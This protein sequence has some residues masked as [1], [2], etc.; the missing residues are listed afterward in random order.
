MEST[1]L[2]KLGMLTAASAMAV[3]VGLGHSTHTFADSGNGN[4]CVGSAVSSNAQLAQQL[5]SEGFGDIIHDEGLNPG[6]LIQA[7]A[8]AN[9]GKHA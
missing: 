8:T 6:D 4:N 5:V 7:Y 1:M 2:R 9:C 3:S